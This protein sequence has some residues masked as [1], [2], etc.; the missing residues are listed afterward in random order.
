MVPAGENNIYHERCASSAGYRSNGSDTDSF[1]TGVQ[2]SHV[3][4][5]HGMVWLLLWWD[6][7]VSMLKVMVVCRIPSIMNDS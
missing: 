2:P 6:L 4:A 7:H 1:Q 3:K 5:I